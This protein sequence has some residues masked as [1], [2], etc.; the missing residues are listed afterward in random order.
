[1]GKIV[2]SR[3]S[4]SKLGA[5]RRFYSSYDPTTADRAVD[6]M[7]ATLTKLILN[8]EIGRPFEGSFFRRELVI[9]FGNNGFIALYDIEKAA[10]RIVVVALRH[11]RESDFSTPSEQ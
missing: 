6:T 11:Q 3:P 10:N 2:F 1:M 7:E 8:P 4:L 9:S 5:I